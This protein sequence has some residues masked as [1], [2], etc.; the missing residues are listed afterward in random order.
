MLDPNQTTAPAAE[1]GEDAKE[2]NFSV[3]TIFGAKS[4]EPLVQVDYLGTTALIE[5]EKAR[6]MAYM[7]LEAAEASLQDA[8]VYLFFQRIGLDEAQVVSALREF[9]VFRQSRAGTPR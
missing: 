4:K 9:R 8:N 6:E 7:L 2:G 5:P 1:L 3:T